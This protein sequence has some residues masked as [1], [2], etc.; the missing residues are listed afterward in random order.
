MWKITFLF[1]SSPSLQCYVLSSQKQCLFS[2]YKSSWILS[3]AKKYNY[4]KYTWPSVKLRRVPPALNMPRKQ[5]QEQWDTVWLE[6]ESSCIA[7]Y[8]NNISGCFKVFA[9]NCTLLLNKQCWWVVSSCTE[10]RSI[11]CAEIKLPSSRN[12]LS[13]NKQL[14]II[15]FL[16]SLV[17]QI[18][19]MKSKN[20]RELV[21]GTSQDIL[22]SCPV[23][24][25]RIN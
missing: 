17:V 1:I 22:I 18:L 24:T 5:C 10:N 14:F 21:Q 23:P 12:S 13:C 15:F 2:V 4:D 19:Q 7:Y 8:N 6:I 16:D 11:L 25:P 9:S 20:I 3:C